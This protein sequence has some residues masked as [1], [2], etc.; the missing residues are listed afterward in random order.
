MNHSLAL[1]HDNIHE[2]SAA[3]VGRIGE[4]LAA[5]Y[6]EQQGYEIVD[7]NYRTRYGEIDIVALDGEALVFVE[8]KTRR[9]YAMG[10]GIL[11]IDERKLA[12]I[13]RMISQY[14]MSASPRHSSVRI[15]A[16]S[17]GLS[18]GHAPSFDHRMAVGA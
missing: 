8:V 7:R 2:L 3:Q 17:I 12:K 1:G 5:H 9:S 10:A 13:R 16:L 6:L 18:Q 11:A 15:D 4:D 14:F